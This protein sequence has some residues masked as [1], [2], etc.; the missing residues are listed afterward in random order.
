MTP[1]QILESVLRTLNEAVQADEHAI[2]MLSEHRVPAS[3]EL[4]EHP[5]IQVDQYG[6]IGLVGII[7]GIVEPL[8]G[9]R[10]AAVIDT[11]EDSKLE[12]IIGFKE[13]VPVETTT[14]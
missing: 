7:N 6:K 11:D 4:Q 9:K 13:Y 1:E 12:W 3:Y 5:T 8:T 14:P 10:V 2:T